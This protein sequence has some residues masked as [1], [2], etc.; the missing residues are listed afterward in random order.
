MT[1]R[2]TQARQSAEP[3]SFLLNWGRIKGFRWGAS[4]GKVIL[5]L[6][7]WLDNAHSF[8]PIAETFLASD[9]AE[10]HQLVALDWPGHG[11]SD[12]RPAG[13]YYPFLDYVFDAIQIC[14]QQGWHEVALLAHSMGAFVGNLWAGIE[15]E[16]ISHLLSIEA[17]GLL[18]S[19]ESAILD[20]IR[21]G[22][23]SRM[24]QQG[25]RRPHY[26]DM[27]SAVAARA[28]AG[29]FSLELAEVLVE[30]GIEQLGEADFRFRAD[31]QLR[32]KSV[33]RLT[34]L[35]I[36]TILQAIRCPIRLIL[37]EQG[38]KERLQVALNEWQHAVPQL[39]VV[40]VPGG[41]HV[42]MEQP[43]AVWRHFTALL[44]GQNG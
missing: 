40:E 28:Q 17:F 15:P 12:H 37:G 2:Y 20:D 16:R 9:L 3:V 24:K 8:L 39:T 13:N 41:H 7:G 29:D 42:H 23:R 5:A 4:D 31:G 22:F 44:A 21:Q 19:P 33:M 38:H 1:E 14:E 27:T 10:S 30:R 34:P 18:S 25:K 35:Q 32:T 11:H 26:A 43:N 6:H 36:R